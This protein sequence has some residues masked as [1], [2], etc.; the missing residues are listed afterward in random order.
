MCLVTQWCPALCNP[1]DYSPSGSSVHGIDSP[2]KNTGVSWHFLLQGN[3][4]DPGIKVTSSV[5]P[6][7]QADSLPAEPS[8][9]PKHSKRDNKYRIFTILQTLKK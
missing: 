3:L 4:P 1:L 8:G 6:A 5:S 9:K 2:S 7:L